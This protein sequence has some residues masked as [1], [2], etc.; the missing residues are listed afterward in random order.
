MINWICQSCG[1]KIRRTNKVPAVI[2]DVAEGTVASVQF[3]KTSTH[4]PPEAVGIRYNKNNW[5]EFP[6]VAE[7]LRN[8]AKSNK[9][10]KS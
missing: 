3:N 2:A 1:N 9:G 4:I 8:V 5:Q 6:I 10:D 7:R